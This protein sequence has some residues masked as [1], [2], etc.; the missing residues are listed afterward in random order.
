LLAERQ[1][2]CFPGR[3][4]LKVD[5]NVETNMRAGRRAYYGAYVVVLI[6][7]VGWPPARAS[8]KA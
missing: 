4:L 5:D 7:T 1:A 3:Y 6:R 2:S 8:Q